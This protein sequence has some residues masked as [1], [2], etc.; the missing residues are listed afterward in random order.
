MNLIKLGRWNKL[1]VTRR[2]DHGVYLDGGDP[3]EV[4]MPRKYVPAGTQLGDEVEAFVYLDQ[5]ERL[6][7]TTEQPKAQVGEFAYLRV[8]WVNRYGAFLDWGVTKDLFVPFREQKMRMEQGRSYVVFPYVDRETARIVGSAKVERFLSSERPPYKQGDRVEGLVWQ[9]TDLGFKVIVDN[10]YAG[11]L[12]DNDVFRPLHTGDRLPLYI[13]RVRDDAKLDLAIQQP[14]FGGLDAFS[15]TLL[16]RL[17]Q[18]GGHLPY[19]DHSDAEA[20]KLTFG[21][22]KKTFKRALGI[23]Y[24]QRLVTMT[25]GGI[26]LATPADGTPTGPTRAADRP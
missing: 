21:V 16:Q 17:Q 26:A 2:T 11:L 15:H 22:S 23:L 13:K 8:A 20:I 9:K 14:G 5:Q 6:V 18:A 1:R 4:L 3:G 12:Y 7:A 19:N 25:N 24:K 10:R